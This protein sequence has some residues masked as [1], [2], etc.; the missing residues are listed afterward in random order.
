MDLG[1][2]GET[3]SDLLDDAGAFATVLAKGVG[4]V[5]FNGFFGKM[6]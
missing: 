2:K 5:G 4:F 1:A 3:A 6:G